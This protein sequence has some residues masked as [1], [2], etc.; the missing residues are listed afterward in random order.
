MRAAPS[1]LKT[2]PYVTARPV[3][4]HRPL[5]PTAAASASSS[6]LS[7]P[8]V[9]ST[10]RFL[11]LATDGLW[12]KLSSE[13]VVTLVAG[14]ISGVR[15]SVSGPS[16]RSKVPISTGAA[17]VEGKDKGLVR[18]D[19]SKAQWAFEDDNLSAHLIRNAFGGADEM[20]L[21]RLMSIPSSHSRAYRDDVT[22]TVVVFPQP[23]EGEAAVKAK[24]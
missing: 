19:A 24:L 18:A 7:K 4:T 12:D 3:V 9:R 16:L 17:G 5:D 1:L 10:P 13:D 11:V 8:V 14:H 15:G 20:A 6:S 2:P 21:R 22:V 23:G